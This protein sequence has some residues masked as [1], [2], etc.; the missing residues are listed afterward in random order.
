MVENINYCNKL[1]KWITTGNPFLASGKPSLA[2]DIWSEKSK[3][4]GYLDEIIIGCDKK[5]K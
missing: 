2:S 4:P 3:L 5:R 1:W